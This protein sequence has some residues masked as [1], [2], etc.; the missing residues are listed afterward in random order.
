M[1][2]SSSRIRQLASSFGSIG[3]SSNVSFEECFDALLELLCSECGE[4]CAQFGEGC[5]GA[6]LVLL[7]YAD[8]DEAD[9]DRPW[10]QTADCACNRDSEIDAGMGLIADS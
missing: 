6:A 3:D 9:E 7:S 1:L 10:G 4:V 5:C 2:P 8:R